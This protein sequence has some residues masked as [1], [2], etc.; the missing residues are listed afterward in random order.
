MAFYSE[1][2]QLYLETDVL[3]VGPETSLLQARDII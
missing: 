1:K 2:E 3:G